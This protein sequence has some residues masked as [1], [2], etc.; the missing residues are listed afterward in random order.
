MFAGCGTEARVLHP[1]FVDCLLVSEFNLNFLDLTV[2]GM[3]ANVVDQVK[4]MYEPCYVLS[5][6][7]VNIV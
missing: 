6:V 1:Y 2:A 5:Q 4:A 7:I 3:K